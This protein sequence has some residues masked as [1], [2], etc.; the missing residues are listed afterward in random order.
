MLFALGIISGLLLSILGVVT[1]LYFKAPIE[2]VVRQTESKFKEKGKIIE[3]EDN[4][5]AAFIDSLKNEDEVS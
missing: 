5:L 2:R 1:L 4:E 3:P